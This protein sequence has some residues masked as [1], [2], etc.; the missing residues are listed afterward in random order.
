MLRILA[1]R[2]GVA[3]TDI[4]PSDLPALLDDPQARVWVDYLGVPDEP[5]R[6]LMRDVFR[7]H[8]LIVEECF[9][10][11]ERPKV[12]VFENYL[13]CITHGL[14]PSSSAE[15]HEVVELD[16]FLG[17]QFL[18][19]YHAKPSRSVEEAFQAVRRTGEPL[20]RGP[21]ALLQGILDRQADGIEPVIDDIENR[22]EILEE[23]VLGS[24]KETD[25]A[26][27]VALRRNI[28]YL[29]RWLGLQRDVVLRLSRQEFTLIPT[30]EAVMFR[31]THDHLARFTEFLETYRELTNSIQDAYLSVTN[32]RLSENMRYLTLFS[33]VLMP[34][35]LLS[36]IYGMNFVHMPGVGHPWGFPLVMGAMVATAFLVLAFFRRKGLITQRGALMGMAATVAK[37]ESKRDAT[38]KPQL[39]RRDS[40][41]FMTRDPGNG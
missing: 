29:R 13:Y 39:A 2:G 26:S 5:L 28:V 9:E 18:V 12:D 16:A 35:T 3:L 31:D 32:N 38:P 34:M 17:R 21:A 7:F 20:R 23:S 40:R 15:D 14:A 24:T 41:V 36:G 30:A 11:R 22:L 19:T 8:P 10:D 33:V 37:D 1:L 6:A 25:L 4:Q 27:L